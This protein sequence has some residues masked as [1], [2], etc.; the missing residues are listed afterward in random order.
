MFQQ[1]FFYLY[2]HLYYW[3]FSHFI[4][5]IDW[6]I[7]FKRCCHNEILF[8]RCRRYDHNNFSN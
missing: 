6:N 5:S 1:M 4:G 8:I 2:I 3:T 7:N